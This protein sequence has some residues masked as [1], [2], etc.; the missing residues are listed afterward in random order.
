MFETTSALSS[1]SVAD[2]SRTNDYWRVYRETW[3]VA[4]SATEPYA[5]RSVHHRYELAHDL[6]HKVAAGFCDVA[7]RIAV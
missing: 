2:E 3:P 4:W 7:S 6:T 1:A 5:S